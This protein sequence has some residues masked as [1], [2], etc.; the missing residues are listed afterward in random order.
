MPKLKEKE[1]ETKN[2]ILKSIVAKKMILYGIS[3]KGDLTLIIG[4]STPTVYKKMKFP[5][6][7]T[8]K[9]IR[10]MDNKF[11]FTAEELREMI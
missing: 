10:R 11:H 1:E 4:G 3:N 6:T 9:E 7:L 8:L 5:E 2:R